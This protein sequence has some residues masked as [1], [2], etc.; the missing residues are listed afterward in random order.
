VAIDRDG[1]IVVERNYLSSPEQLELLPRAASG[2][3]AMRAAGLELIVVTNQ[4][5]VGRGLIDLAR[6]EEIHVRFRKLLSAAGIEIAGI[7]VC[8]HTAEDGCGCRKPL[9]GLLL[10]AANEL[11]FLPRDVLVIGDKRTDI[12]LG[13]AVGATTILV[14]TGYGASHEATGGVLADH[15]ADDL[16]TAAEIA[17]RWKDNGESLAQRR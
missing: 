10:Q 12:D 7:Y 8:P 2:L 4:S 6:L 1:T 3:R 17:V 13:R 14:R 9:P 5:A 16:F 11:A 15:I